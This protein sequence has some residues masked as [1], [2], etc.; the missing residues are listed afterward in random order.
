MMYW[1]GFTD[2]TDNFEYWNLFRNSSVTFQSLAEKYPDSTLW[3]S[4]PG[5]DDLD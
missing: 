2:L 3:D 5:Y 1:L 4:S